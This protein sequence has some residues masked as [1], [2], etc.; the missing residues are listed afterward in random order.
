MEG[1]AF[2]SLPHRGSID[3]D[4][5]VAEIFLEMPSLVDLGGSNTYR[6]SAHECVSLPAWLDHAL[7]L[8]PSDDVVGTR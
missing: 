4:V 8:Y 1:S 3:D 2:D 7:R 5:E 6:A